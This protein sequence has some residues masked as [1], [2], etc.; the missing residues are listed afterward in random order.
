MS[1]DQGG[2]NDLRT[3]RRGGTVL[4]ERH[5]NSQGEGGIM[6]LPRIAIATGDPAGIG[7]EIALKAVLDARVLKLCRPLLIGDPAAVELHARAA[8]LLPK[9]NVIEKAT[10]ADWTNGAVN[11]LDTCDGSNA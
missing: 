2:N 11:L 6:L 10:D 3:A 9:L 5:R 7:P 1:R 4:E 8:G